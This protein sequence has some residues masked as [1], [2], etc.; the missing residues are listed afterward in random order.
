[1]AV[2][3]ATLSHLWR[4]AKALDIVA[5]RPPFFVLPTSQLPSAKIVHFFNVSDEKFVLSFALAASRSVT[6]DSPGVDNLIREMFRRMIGFQT[7][8][9]HGD[10]K[11][12]NDFLEQIS[13]IVESRRVPIILNISNTLSCSRGRYGGRITWLNSSLDVVEPESRQLCTVSD[14]DV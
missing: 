10:V 13:L 11:W 5:R 1:M 6:E 4:S 12:S 3:E 2:Y 14:P 8:P 9:S 7:L